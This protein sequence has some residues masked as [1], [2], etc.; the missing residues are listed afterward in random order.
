MANPPEHEQP[1][2]HE[3]F[4]RT[5]VILLVVISLSMFVS[6]MNVMGLQPF[7]VDIGED[8]GV[9]VPAAGQA[10]TITL[11]FSA[12]SGLIAGP[13]ADHFGHRRLMVAGGIILALS[14]IGTALALNYVLFMGARLFAGMSLALLNGLSLAIAGSFFAGKAR[15]R[16]LSVTVAAMSG[17]AILGVPA[18]SWV[19]D[20]FSWRWAFAGVGATAVVLTPLLYLIIPLKLGDTAGFRL[21]QIVSAYRPLFRQRSVLVVYLGSLIRAIFWLGMLTYFGAFMIEEHGLSLQ[22]VGYTYLV[23]GVGFLLGSLSAGGRIGSFDHRT[24]FTVVTISGA[25]LF[26]IAYS[27]PTGPI[28]SVLA[29][30]AGGY[31]GAIGWVI[32]NTMLAD[33]SEAGSGTTMSLNTAVFNLGSAAG[34]AVG[35]AVLAAS[36][37]AGL[38]FVLPLFAVIASAIVM[39]SAW[40][41]NRREAGDTAG[42]IASPETA[43]APVTDSQR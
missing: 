36:S 28:V 35:G 5:G 12:V 24:L 15:R 25:V 20:V 7:F 32:L 6:G 38:G 13:L 34:G 21:S 37:Y 26:G 27:A 1:H 4:D 42:S 17:T 41:K 19:G 18:L 23:G 33:E 31:F 2:P 14:A 9:S 10:M 8:L 22:Q 39:G 11:L 30:A 43:Q 16:A 3:S 40:I 29:L